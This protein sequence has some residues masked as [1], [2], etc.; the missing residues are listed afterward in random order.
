[1]RTPNPHPAFVHIS[2]EKLRL[3]EISTLVSG[4]AGGPLSLE[5]F[6]FYC[7]RL[8]VPKPSPTSLKRCISNTQ[9]SRSVAKT[10]GQCP[11]FLSR[12]FA[13]CESWRL[14]RRTPAPHNC[15]GWSGGWQ[16]SRSLCSFQIIARATNP[17]PHC[18]QPGGQPDSPSEQ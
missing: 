11:I 3:R 7:L 8:S 2:R 17:L 13:W 12:E 18:S 14:K 1:M 6:F 4:P 16:K 9:P 15:G 10:L 5:D